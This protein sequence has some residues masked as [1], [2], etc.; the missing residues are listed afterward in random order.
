M[1]NLK[2][3]VNSL[4]EN[5]NLYKMNAFYD[6]VMFLKLILNRGLN[7]NGRRQTNAST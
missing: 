7:C 5:Y 2:R 3:K 6:S 1:L 4:K